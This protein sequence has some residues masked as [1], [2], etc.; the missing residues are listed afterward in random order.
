[1]I[2]MHFLKPE[3]LSLRPF[4][5]LPLVAIFG[6]EK[7]ALGFGEVESVMKMIFHSVRQ[8]VRISRGSCATL[9]NTPLLFF[10]MEPFR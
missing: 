9:S 2:A 10:H 3:A 5:A 4:I 8:N 7:C 6:S 1:M